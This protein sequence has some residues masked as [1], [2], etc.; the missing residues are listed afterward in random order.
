MLSKTI[1]YTDFNDVKKEKTYFFN[2]TDAELTQLQFSTPGGLEKKLED[3]IA[4][5]DMKEILSIFKEII[6]LS[7]GVKSEDGERFEKSEKLR[8]EF[9]QTAAFSALYMELLDDEKAAE[10]INGIVP[11]DKRM[12]KAELDKN[13][14]DA[15]ER[16]GIPQPEKEENTESVETVEAEV[17]DIPQN[18]ENN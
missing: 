10:F 5:E 6:L 13:M 8:E 9:S 1:K 14:A 17:V 16:V 2:L 7:Y 12:S 3:I 15:A 11:K 18:T 4:S